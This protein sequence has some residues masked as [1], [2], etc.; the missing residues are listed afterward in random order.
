M[1]ERWVQHISG[2]GKKYEVHDHI[3]GRWLVKHELHVDQ[4]R[5]L[6]LPKD[7]YKECEPPEFWEDVTEHCVV[8]RYEDRGWGELNNYMRMTHMAGDQTG[9]VFC[10]EGYRLRKV[11]LPVAL[12]NGNV[13]EQWA[14]IIERKKS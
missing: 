1:A 14:F 12:T 2:Q 8:G 10:E 4:W 6:E 11:K 7:E 9:R 3:T 13:A 5:C